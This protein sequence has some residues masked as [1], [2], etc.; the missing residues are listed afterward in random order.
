MLLAAGEMPL[1]RLAVSVI[2]KCEEGLVNSWIFAQF[3]MKRG[4]HCPTL[5]HDDRIV[6]FRG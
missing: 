2:Y 3:R 5:A 4:C 6:P 1:L